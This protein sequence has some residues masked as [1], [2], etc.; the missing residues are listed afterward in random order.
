MRARLA[1]AAAGVRGRQQG[2]PYK[3]IK[4]PVEEMGRSATVVKVVMDINVGLLR[5]DDLKRKKVSEK[6]GGDGNDVLLWQATCKKGAESVH[7]DQRLR[8][9]Q[10]RATRLRVLRGGVVTR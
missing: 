6:N 5:Q 10:V 7:L 8:R 9:Q 4:E 1:H 2:V 3:L